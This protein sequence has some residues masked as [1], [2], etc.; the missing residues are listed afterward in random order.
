VQLRLRQGFQSC[1]CRWPSTW[2]LL[3]ECLAYYY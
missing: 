2:I 3:S 1:V